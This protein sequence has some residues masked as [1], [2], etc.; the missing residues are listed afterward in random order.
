MRRIDEREGEREE[1][2]AGGERD[3]EL[4]RTRV[5]ACVGVCGRRGRGVIVSFF[6]YINFSCLTA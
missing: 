5:L 2:E 4:D 1:R 6:Y 3:K